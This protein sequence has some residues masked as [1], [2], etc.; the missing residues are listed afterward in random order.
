MSEDAVDAISEQH[1]GRSW[2]RSVRVVAFFALAGPLAGVVSFALGFAVLMLLEPPPDPDWI[3][4]I[5]TSGKMFLLIMAFGIPTGYAIGF[6]PALGVGIVAGLWQW[7]S[8]RISWIVI[9][10]A[11]FAVWLVPYL[12]SGDLYVSEAIRLSRTNALLPS[13]MAAAVICTWLARRI[14]R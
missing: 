4:G 13:F 9:L 5:L 7:W 2:P 3:E 1:P 11:T 12:Q 6:L 8:G 14:F 10:A